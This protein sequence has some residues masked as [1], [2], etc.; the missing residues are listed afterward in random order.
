MKLVCTLVCV[1]GCAG[2]F[3]DGL[4]A[5]AGATE[6]VAVGTLACDLGETADAL[7]L[8]GYE[9]NPILGPHPAVA[10]VSWYFASVIAAVVLVN[11]ALPHSLDGVRVGGNSL[12][13]VAEAVTL[14]HNHGTNV[15]LCGVTR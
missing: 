12:L 3:G 2:T 5:A 1:A 6:A 7:S 13:I 14:A 10:S 8:P 15:P 11:A 4:H 9:S